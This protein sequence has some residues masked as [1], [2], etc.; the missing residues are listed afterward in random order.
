M[1]VPAMPGKK[2]TGKTADFLLDRCFYLNLFI[3]QLARIPYIMSSE[4]M[5][6]FF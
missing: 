3:K 5:K 6:I 1:Y 2:K 4:E